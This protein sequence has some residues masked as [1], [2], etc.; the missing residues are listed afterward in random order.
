MR[1]DA[2]VFG[3]FDDH[4]ADHRHHL[5]EHLA[6]FL[7]EQ[8]VLGADAFGGRA[9]QEAEVVADVVG[10]HRL[11][12]RTQDFPTALGQISVLDDHGRGHVTEDEVAVAVLEVQVARADLGIDHQHSLG[13][14]GG[15]EVGGGLDA[16]GGRR[17]GHVHVEGEAVDTQGLLH[18]DGHGRVGA[19]HVRGR[20]DHCADLA[21]RLA[22]ARDG[23]LGGFDGHLGQDRQLVVAALGQVG[24]H[25]LG[26]DDAVLVHHE[27]RLDAR[28]LLD[29]FGRG[30]GEGGDLAGRD[31]LGV[32]GVEALNEGVEGLDQ[33]GVRN[34]VGRGVEAGGGDDG[35]RQDD[36]PDDAR[37]PRP[38]RGRVRVL[39]LV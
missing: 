34:A 10:E 36:C 17:T 25:D 12:P 23:V 33:L 18:L 8:L 7:D 26:V 16:E 37:E 28:G 1:V 13:A 9:V 6:A 14:A 15:D 32:G 22:P 29:E 31:G 20:A 4:L 39:T 21:D 3:V 5:A 35:L 27:A 2:D 30:G 24:P 19:L 11:Q 38:L